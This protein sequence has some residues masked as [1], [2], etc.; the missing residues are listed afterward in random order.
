MIDQ[1]RKHFVLAESM[2]EMECTCLTPAVVLQTSG[3]V[4]RFTDLMVKDPETGEC[5]RADKLLEDAID[6]LIESSPDMPKEERE[7]H[8]RIQRQADAYSPEE[9]DDLLANKYNCK[10]PS[11]QPYSNAFPFNLMFK[12]SIGPE[13]T[14]VGYL[15]P[16]TAQGLF[17]NFR[18]LLDANAGK[19]PFAAA[20]I[21]L[22]FRNGEWLCIGDL[23]N[24]L[25]S[26]I[27]RKYQN[28]SLFLF[29]LSFSS[30]RFFF[31][32]A[33]CYFYY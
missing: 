29:P 4:E 24:I 23:S 27:S 1:W 22:G 15:R 18:R 28:I 21:G 11:G 12:T 5:F 19:M 33:M 16:E 14:A 17:V 20:Q 7:D 30:S 31:R 25:G 3:H 8:L 26:D 9:I 10:A 32:A 2:L 6:V 13:G